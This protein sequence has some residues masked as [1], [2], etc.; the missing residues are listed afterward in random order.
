MQS[1]K[2]HAYENLRYRIITQELPPGELLKESD[3]MEHYGIGR[4]PLREII[5]ELQRQ[6]LIRR[7]PRTGTWVA[8]MAPL[9]E[10]VEV[11]HGYCPVCAAQAFAQLRRRGAK[12]AGARAKST[13]A[14]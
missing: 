2:K 8:P 9:E 10:G 14:A 6:G 7:V 11:T 3:L 13:H 4:T 5:I 12:A 1:N